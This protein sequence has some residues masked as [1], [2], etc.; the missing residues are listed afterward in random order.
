MFDNGP[1]HS[2]LREGMSAREWVVEGFDVP[3]QFERDSGILS[4]PEVRR[5][6]PP[7]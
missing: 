5:F 4:L 2:D 1:F 6:L 3:S 7:I